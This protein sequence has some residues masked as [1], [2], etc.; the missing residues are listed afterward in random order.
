MTCRNR[1]DHQA[2]FT[3]ESRPCKECLA[4]ANWRAWG[5]RSSPQG[6]KRTDRPSRSNNRRAHFRFEFRICCE[7]EGWAT[8]SY[9]DARVKPPMRHR[10]EV[11]SMTGDVRKYTTAKQFDS[12]TSY[13]P[14]RPSHLKSLRLM[15]GQNSLSTCPT[16][17]VPM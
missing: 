8:P 11:A 6:V 13:F 1:T 2:A 16:I 4:S 17:S 12:P 7:S 10:A 15:S 3:P 9:S 14:R 5:S